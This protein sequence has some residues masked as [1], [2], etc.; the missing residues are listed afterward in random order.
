MIFGTLPGGAPVELF[1]LSSDKLTVRISNYGGRI[2]SVV[3]DGMDMIVGPKHFEDMLKDTCYCGAICGRVANRIAKGR[4]SID[5][6]SRTVAVNNGPN[7]LHGGIQGFDSKVWQVQE[8]GRNTLV[9]TLHS[10]DGEENYPGNLEVVA[11][12][13]VV[14][15]TLHLRLEAYADAA[16]I[17]NLTNHAY[18]N[19]SGKP[20][21]DSMTL[22]VRASAYTPVD[23][24]NIP[25]GRILPVEGTD[26]DLR[27]AALLG[28]RNSAAHPDTAAGLDHNY[29]LDSE[30]GDKIA[31]ILLDPES[32][33]R[34]IVATDAPGLQ[35]Y[36]GEYLP[37]AR[38]GIALEAQGFPNAVNTPPLPQRH[39][40][41]RPIRHAQHYLD[42]QI[43]G[44]P[45][46]RFRTKNG[47]S[48]TPAAGF[49][50]QARGI[51][52]PR[53]AL[54]PLP[55]GALPR[56]VPGNG[57]QKPDP[58]RKPDCPDIAQASRQMPPSGT[59][60]APP[61]P[62]AQGQAPPEPPRPRRKQPYS[63]P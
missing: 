14:E 12:Y 34:L 61:N 28:E 57:L 6:D 63:Q 60:H 17:V 1:E 47:A 44:M 26:F 15:E 5:G 16:T 55:F 62:P 7:H 13:T 41:S 31:A 27:K 35:V 49:P 10:A 24:T 58:Q 37:Q 20:T 18:W 4:F 59:P 36:T 2:I 9:L 50:V 19:L 22:E 56:C 38:Q 53:K 29:V 30:P 54:P 21:I 40:A 48:T 43:G 51:R 3:K 33:H 39:S 32:R 42:C 52:R 23:A 11:T 46:S 45:E 25:D 8:A